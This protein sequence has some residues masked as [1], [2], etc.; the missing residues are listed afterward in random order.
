VRCLGSRARPAVEQALDLLAGSG[1]L[2]EGPALSP[3]LPRPFAETAEHLTATAPLEIPVAEVS[4]RLRDATIGVIGAGRRAEDV[5]R[6]LA[7]SGVGATEA[8]GWTPPEADL[9]ALA[10][11]VAVPEARDLECLGPWNRVALSRGVEWLQLSPFDGRLAA[12]GPVFVPGETCCFECYRLRRESNAPYRED[13]SLLARSPAPLPSAPALEQVVLGLGAHVA[14]RWLAYR[15]AALAG[16]FH[17]VVQG[18][19]FA[20]TF[21][22]VFRV[23]R[24]P[25]C[26]TARDVGLPL[27][28]FEGASR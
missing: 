13:C 27:P 25:A 2:T 3:D 11:V 5:A 16:S 26:S 22:H 9:A 24:C 18:E 6:L 21:H 15:D 12:V 1:V 4:A 7:L 17:A 10:L 28:W 20:V 8:L 19:T 23:P 14:L